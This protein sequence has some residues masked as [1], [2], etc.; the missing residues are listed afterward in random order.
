MSFWA[1]RFTNKY[2]INTAYVLTICHS[3]HG[4]E[5]EQFWQKFSDL[6]TAKNLARLALLLRNNSYKANRKFALLLGLIL[7]S[8]IVQDPSHTLRVTYFLV[9]IPII[10]RVTYFLI[11][12][13]IRSGWHEFIT[14]FRVARDWFCWW[15][16]LQ[17]FLGRARLD[18]LCDSRRKVGLRGR[19]EATG[20]ARP[21][22]QE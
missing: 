12:L 6:I 1:E 22:L 9:L 5:P 8:T 16:K 10:H 11:L 7:K 15:L 20:G 13:C 21:V 2:I 19:A 17:L 4:E 18:K 14:I 3:E